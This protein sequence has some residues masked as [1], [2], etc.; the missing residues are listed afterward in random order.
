MTRSFRE[1]KSWSSPS[2]RNTSVACRGWKS[3][4]TCSN[5]NLS[6]YGL[7][8]IFVDERTVGRGLAPRRNAEGR[9]PCADENAHAPMNGAAGASRRGASPISANHLTIRTGFPVEKQK[10]AQLRESCS[11]Q[12][13]RRKYELG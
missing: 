5:K 10:V 3:C 11:R 9:S 6:R 7:D 2:S 8:R 1:R 4:A 12:N 13:Y